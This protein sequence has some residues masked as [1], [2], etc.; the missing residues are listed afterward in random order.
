M[1]VEAEREYVRIHTDGKSYFVRG[2]LSDFE[3]RLSE[4]GMV[5]VHR[6]AQVRAAAIE[7]IEAQDNRGYG[8]IL[9][10]GDAVR[11]S[12]LFGSRVREL[13]GLIG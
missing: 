8:L 2:R 7:R 10:N 4:H 9:S 12:R 13:T 6:S 3:A 1:W 5:R 11:A